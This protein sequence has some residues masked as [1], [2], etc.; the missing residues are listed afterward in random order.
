M[1]ILYENPTPAQ[2]PKKQHLLPVLTVLF[3][4]SYG[5]MTMLIVEQAS[6]IQSQRTLILELFRDSNELSAL[7]IKV[8]NE[9]RGSAAQAVPQQTPSTQA[10]APSSQVPSG[11]VPSVHAPSSQTPSAQAPQLRAGNERNA[12]K[13]QKHE[14]QR[15]ARP[16]SDVS[17]VRRALKSI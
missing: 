16:E 8:H 17:D 14:M 13:T 11:Q 2:A 9:H 6:T 5:L 10:Q 4:I 1:T 15:P 3:L 12:A 7:K